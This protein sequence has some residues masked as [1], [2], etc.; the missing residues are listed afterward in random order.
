MQISLKW[1]NELVEIETI[2]L[3]DLVEKLT[4][5][6]FEVEEILEIE[7]NNQKQIILDISATANR[8]DS[9]SIQGLSKEIST[10][11]DQPIK[12]SQYFLEQNNW[13]QNLS[14][15]T[16]ILSINSDCSIFVTGIV[17][18][19]DNFNVPVWIK[20]KLLS[21]GFIPENNLNDFQ[22][23]ILLES[24]Y[25]FEFYDVEKIYSALKTK[26]FKI[27]IQ[28]AKKNQ[29]FLAKNGFEYY[30]DNSV[31][32]INVNDLP[33]S[34][35]GF[36]EAKVV[37][38]SN[39]TTKLLI[40]GSIFS[41][42][43]IRQQSRHLGLRTDRSARYEK[44]L[45][46][47]HLFESLYR[48]VSLLR[49]SNPNLNWRFHTI[50]KILEKPLESILLRYETIHEILGPTKNI[51]NTNS[52]SIDVETINSYLKRLDFEFFYNDSTIS[53]NVKI[54]RYRSE[55][56]SREIDL[57]EEIGRLHGFNNF[58][59]T[60]PK[61]KAIGIE[62]STYQTRKKITSCLLNL[63][64]NELI[65]YSLVD[66][67]RLV[68]NEVNLINP[69]L[70]D[71]SSLRLSLLPKL[72]KTVQENSN[73]K[74]L[75][76]EGFEYGHI[77]YR[78]PKLK[79]KERESV[80]GIFGGLKSKLTW[81][82]SERGLTWFEAKGKLEQFLIQLNLLT[83]WQK[84]SLT[85]R[86]KLFHP[87]AC[88]DIFLKSGKFLGIFGQLHPFVA[89]QLNI[90]PK[91]YLFEF[92]LKV[93][94]EQ[95]QVNQISFQ[96]SYSLYP[97]IIKDI[98]LIISKKTTFHQLKEVLYLNGTESL[99][100]INLLDEYRGQ[101]IP[102]DSKSLCFEL[103]FQSDRKTLENKKIETILQ[104]LKL[105]LTQKFKAQIRN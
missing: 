25:P 91:I 66:Q 11:L 31:Q 87:Y 74:N 75:S 77:F 46:N 50:Q 83:Y 38:I 53:W 12:K 18:N 27:S 16:E 4:L 80:G 44:S 40:E 15:K 39:N 9:L 54:P 70:S 82:D 28:N 98:S 71:C 5:G 103:I 69:L 99:S 35:A 73:Q 36:M 1:I 78:D 47:T 58:V 93:I 97:R 51:K 76:V 19:L 2:E 67:E 86:D 26:D 37:S 22:N 30:L 60:L 81:T 8:S 56:I 29:K 101:S 33:I 21:S 41:A 64:F 104:N 7:I 96:K 57:I 42:R 63:G 13:I 32:T 88:A 100:E 14:K 20:Q 48:L 61:L 6:G 52:N 94:D 24:G 95:L 84:S 79:F 3:D 49:I 17:E 59:T 45:K 43:K 65:H 105:I 89:N 10:L 85:N 55:D 72:I 68:T 34:I 90:S 102:A 92:N 62:D 23:Y